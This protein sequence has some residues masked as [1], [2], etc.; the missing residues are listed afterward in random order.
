MSCHLKDM[1]NKSCFGF[2]NSLCDIL[3]ILFIRRNNRISDNY[4]GNKSNISHYYLISAYMCIY[5][6]IYFPL[7]YLSIGIIPYT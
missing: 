3:S 5:S 2:L 1:R 7:Y 6:L 4:N